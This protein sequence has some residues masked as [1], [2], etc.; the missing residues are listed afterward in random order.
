MKS[1]I[2]LNN[3]YGRLTVIQKTG[4]Q[5]QHSLFECFCECGVIVAVKGIHLANGHTKSCGC[6]MREETTRRNLAK[7]KKDNTFYHY[8]RNAKR[9]NIQFS[10]T[11]EQFQVIRNNKCSY[12]PKIG[13]N[14]VDRIDNNK[15]Y[16]LDNCTSCCKKCN[17]AKGTMTVTEFKNWI[18]EVYNTIGETDA[19]KS[20]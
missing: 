6:F 14:G 1:S 4:T 2:K 11:E 9:R 7:G 19:T 15:G 13:P 3:K 17:M 5:N 8:I 12:C 18:I 20:T 16:T 10:L